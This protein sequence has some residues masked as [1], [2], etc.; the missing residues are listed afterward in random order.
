MMSQ[1]R[2]STGRYTH[3]VSDPLRL[4]T[5]ASITAD[6]KTAVCTDRK[7]FEARVPLLVLPGKGV[8]PAVGENWYITQKSG[9]TWTFDTFIGSDSTQLATSSG[10]LPITYGTPPADTVIDQDGNIL[11]Y[12]GN[13]KLGQALASQPGTDGTTEFPAG[14]GSFTLPVLIYA[15][16]PARG[17][18]VVSIAGEAGED[19]FGNSYPAGANITEGNLP[20]ALLSGSISTSMLSGTIP[21]TQIT[22]TLA[23]STTP[24]TGGI[25]SS[26]PYFTN[27]D[28]ANWVA[29]GGILSATQV[30]GSPFSWAAKV[31]S[32]GTA[33]FGINGTGLN[34]ISATPGT[35][36]LVSAWVYANGATSGAQLGM[37]WKTASGGSL[38]GSIQTPALTANS[39]TPLAVVVT[40]PA[41]AATGIPQIGFASAS[42]TGMQGYICAAIVLPQVPGGLIEVG[43]IT[44][45]QIAAGTIVAGIVDSTL[46]TG[47]ILQGGVVEGGQVIGGLVEADSSSG[48]FFAYSAPP[49]PLNQNYTFATG[50]SP[51][52][53]FDNAG[54]A[55]SSLHTIGQSPGSMVITP[56]GVT[57]NPGA[58]SENTIPVTVGPNF[59]GAT[60]MVTVP[61]GWSSGMRVNIRWFNGATFLSQNSGTTVPIP[62]NTPTQLTA[63]FSAPVGA[64]RASM[65]I[66][67]VGT[68]AS[69]VLAYVGLA[70]FGNNGTLIVT[71]AS[72]S[73]TDQFANSYIAGVTSYTQDSGFTFYCNMFDGALTVYVED[74]FG[75]APGLID[76]SAVP[77][78][79]T[80][81]LQ[82][83][84]ASSSGDLAVQMWLSSKNSG[85]S[86]TEAVVIGQSIPTPPVPGPRIFQILGNQ[87]V[88]T[89]YAW[90]PGTTIEET[91]QSLGT[92]AGATVN[93]ARYRMMPDGM[94]HVQVD[95]TFGSATAVPITFSN[96]LP[97]A[98][99]P[100]STDVDIRAPMAQTN[101]SGALA[102]IFVG[103]QGGGNPGQVQL[104]AIGTVIG[105]YSTNFQYP[106]I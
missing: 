106:V 64:T 99:R 50:I 48:G 8:L 3:S 78:N 74:G 16:A 41:N 24:N 70:V 57:A 87:N 13:G 11:Q 67:F 47:A 40:A 72:T 63:A 30:T 6:G 15:G 10:S 84:T 1:G 85:G 39:W 102:R 43:T 82:S 105:T 92:L 69:S 21:A 98:Y 52:S 29:F 83:G 96:T 68:P 31:V 33:A 5:I 2:P 36:Y 100:L 20:A 104:A 44:A 51:W 9:T 60:A 34:Q 86:S 79:G 66:T 103:Q 53:S 19:V 35:Q 77:A 27:G 90:S 62:A 81:R 73:A 25:L 17:N 32:S 65:T 80:L 23:G 58:V 7:G 4:V 37:N 12:D 56:D 22:G 61:A 42:G 28:L 88:G 95:V 38:T 14:L 75:G 59:Y 18:L 101:A 26:N 91:W 76:N 94:V 46:V 93:K 55:A 49:G 45:A 71:G 97:V 54:V 89:I